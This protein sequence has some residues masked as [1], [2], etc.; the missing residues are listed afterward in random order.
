[1]NELLVR[2][3][4]RRA[5]SCCEYCRIPQNY[6]PSPFEIDHIIARQHDGPTSLDNLALACLH[7]NAHKGPNLSGLDPQ[8]GQLTR[9][10]H[11]RRHM[12]LHTNRFRNFNVLK[13]SIASAMLHRISACGHNSRHPAPRR[14][15]PREASTSHVVGMICA[16][17][18]KK[19]GIESSGNT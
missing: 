9:L 3:V 11:P 7:C 14:I 2:Q 12:F 6:F 13:A 15:T 18:Q 16:I 17:H 1:M 19:S 10:F 8:T 5:K 4:W